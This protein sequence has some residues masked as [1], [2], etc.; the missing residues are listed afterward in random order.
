MF[1]NNAFT[2]HTLEIL[3]MLLGA[4]V[5][6]LWL[7]WV[8]WGRLKAELDR[9]RIENQS[10]VVTL[11]AIRLEIDAVKTRAM[12]AENEQTAYAAQ[13][14]D[15]NHDN[16]A[17][18]E[19]NMFLDKELEQI[20]A[21]NRQLETELGLSYTPDTPLA[22]DI[23]EEI[24]KLV[25]DTPPPAETKA[26]VETEIKVIVKSEILTP[27]VL[28][29]Q[30]VSLS[31]DTIEKKPKPNKSKN[32]VA[33][34]PAPTPDSEKDDLTVIEGIG[35][36]IQMLLNQFDIKTYRQLTEADVVRLKEILATAGPQL[37]MHDPGT[38]PSQANLAANDQWDTLK[39]VQGF[40]KGGKKPD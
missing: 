14:A 33:A 16:I 36:K 38:W 19:R 18:R 13:V 12:T 4:F 20:A 22:D 32:M 11:D 23:P 40:L 35:P 8:I 34:E 24:K 5:I 17:L 10:N 27:P 29:V 7:G 26:P 1:A 39:S 31:D 25:Q 3:I 28:I 37:A 6:G 15:F 9:L 30:P 21:R 2:T